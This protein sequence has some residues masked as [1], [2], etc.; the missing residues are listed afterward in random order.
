MKTILIILVSVHLTFLFC[1]FVAPYDESAQDR[2]ASYAPPTK[3]HAELSSRPHIYVCAWPE[4]EQSP[5]EY[6][7]DC[8]QRYGLHLFVRQSSL[9]LF[10]VDAP[11]RISLFGTDSLGRDQ[12]SRFLFG[13]R[14]SLFA[15][16][17]ATAL[18]LLL[19][20]VIGML[21]GF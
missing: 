17:L 1:G 6:S 5:G 21:A 11:G 10:G 9:H 19:G 16:L 4:K 20:I 2:N 15:G 18:A 8:S 3:L 14:L 13:A 7:E 12:F